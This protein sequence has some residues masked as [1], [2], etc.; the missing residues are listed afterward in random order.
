MGEA[1]VE[2]AAVGQAGQAIFVR[3][4][5]ELLRLL[6]QALAQCVV[7]APCRQQL[8]LALAQTGIALFQLCRQPRAFPPCA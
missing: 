2:G 6:V 4:P 5:F 3:L 8:R 7:V 1:F